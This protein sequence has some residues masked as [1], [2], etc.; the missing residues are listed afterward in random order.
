MGRKPFLGFLALVS[1]LYLS[2]TRLRSHGIGQCT[3]AWHP[4]PVL[5]MAALAGAEMENQAAGSTKES[6][7]K[8]VDPPAPEKP[9]S[10]LQAPLV[11][12]LQ[13]ALLS[14]LQSYLTGLRVKQKGSFVGAGVI[15]AS[16]LLKS[17][18]YL[19]AQWPGRFG[20]QSF[21]KTCSN[22]SSTLLPFAPAVSI[23]LT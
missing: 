9:S 17:C 10:E 15:Q 22:C 14:P 16:W 2:I 13:V 20:G 3:N 11:T 6:Q 21:C 19:D 7:A 8:S 4:T 23:N 5:Q 1:L 12:S 18:L